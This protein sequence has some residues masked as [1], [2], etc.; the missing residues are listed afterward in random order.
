MEYTVLLACRDIALL[1]FRGGAARLAIILHG[2]SDITHTGS[3]TTTALRRAFAPST[4]GLQV[5]IHRA[6][7]KVAFPLSCQ[8]QALGTNHFEILTTGM[9]QYAPDE[10][11]LTSSAHRGACLW[12]PFCHLAILEET[13]VTCLHLLENIT[14]DLLQSTELS[15]KVNVVLATDLHLLQQIIIVPLVFLR[16]LTTLLPGSRLLLSGRGQLCLSRGQQRII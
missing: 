2:H 1:C 6:W 15:L 16:H 14:A 9:S 4:P 7:A 11:L 12:C 8:W 10:L 3:Q 5:A 13:L